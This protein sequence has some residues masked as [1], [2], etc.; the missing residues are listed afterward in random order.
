MGNVLFPFS[1]GNVTNPQSF[2]YNF[3]G[4]ASLNGL[5]TEVIQYT[6]RNKDAIKYQDCGNTGFG[7]MIDGDL[8]I[9]QFFHDK[10]EIAYAG[11][12]LW[13]TKNPPYNTWTEEITFILAYGGTAT[14]TWKLAQI[15]ANASANLLVAQRT[16]TN[17]LVLT[18]GPLDPCQIP[19]LHKPGCPPGVETGPLELTAA[20]MSQ[21]NTRVAATAIA[22]SISGQ[23]H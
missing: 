18:L 12:G 17:D 21:H 3:G 23:T 5:R 20:A 7:M 10:A 16:N 8:K 11:N 14:P 4:T 6:V 2:S 22:T 1:T 19:P 13:D 9:K 15:S